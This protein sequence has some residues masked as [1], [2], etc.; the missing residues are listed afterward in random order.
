[1][2][3][4]NGW[5]NV[6]QVIKAPLIFLS[7]LLTQENMQLLSQVALP[8]AS[9][10]PDYNEIGHLGRI[11]RAMI[12]VNTVSSVVVSPCGG[13]CSHRAFCFCRAF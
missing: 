10:N 2:Q 11:A 8:Q 3:R 1:M 6:R 9:V 5:G 13:F 7:A 12:E 4:M